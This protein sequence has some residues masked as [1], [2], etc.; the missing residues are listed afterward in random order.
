MSSAKNNL[1]SLFFDPKKR[2]GLSLFGHQR[3]A[4]FTTNFS[5]F[6]SRHSKQLKGKKK[7]KK[8]PPLFALSKQESFVVKQRTKVPH[9]N[10]DSKSHH[11]HHHHHVWCIVVVV[12]VGTAA[13]GAPLRGDRDD[14]RDDQRVRVVAVRVGRRV[15]DFETFEKENDGETLGG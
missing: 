5:L 11:Q 3:V 13:P 4:F 1:T 14:G 9:Q 7:K 6:F 15:G 10:D 2:K 12:V 8:K